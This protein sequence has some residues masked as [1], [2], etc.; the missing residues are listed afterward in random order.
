MKL[1]VP[2][3]GAYIFIYIYIYNHYIFLILFSTNMSRS[4]SVLT[5]FGLKSAL[6]DMNVAT[7]FCLLRMLFITQSAYILV[8]EECFL[9]AVNNWILKNPNN[10]IGL[11]KWRV[12]IIYIHGY[13]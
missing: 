13:N 1:G 8:S 10:L 2:T 7:G 12:N 6:S 4:L 3:F 9:K 5:N 11:F